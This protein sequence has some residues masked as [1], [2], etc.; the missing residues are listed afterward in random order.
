MTIKKKL[1][2]KRQHGQYK[3]VL[4]FGNPDWTQLS[5]EIIDYIQNAERP[6][7]DFVEGEWY[8]ISFQRTISS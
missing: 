8:D 6:D 3:C 2:L 1:L 7:D 4:I 5:T